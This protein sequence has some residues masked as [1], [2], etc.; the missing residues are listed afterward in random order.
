MSMDHL[1]RGHAPIPDAAW[2]E[3]DQEAKDRLT[4]LLAA[5][6]VVDWSGP[7]GWQW[8]STSLG[9]TEEISAPSLTSDASEH[10]ETTRVRRRK[11]LP[12]AEIRVGFTLD[13]DELVDVS[14]GALDADLGA[15]D[16]AAQRVAAL[17]NHAVFHGWP[18]AGM[19][20]ITTTQPSYRL[21]DDAN[22]FPATIARS[23][24]TLDRSGIGGPYALVI[25]PVGY[26]CIMET[27]EHGGYPLIEHL[28]TILGGPVI[29][30]PGVEGALVVTQRGGD[31]LF[32]SGQD[33]SVGYLS[34]DAETVD[35][36][37]E[38]SFTFR[39]VE[40]DAAVRL[41]D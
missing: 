30:A 18:A 1:I 34:H 20:G 21:G 17:E 8:S 2:Q 32:E 12:V 24:D 31:F 38:E 39:C 23:V 7:H 26:T 5:R 15:L 19:D 3:I 10:D 37:L 16:H 29:S 6:R 14:R 4:P 9:R 25:G 40:D 28:R 35:L 33:L 11:V 27:A 41:T 13:R 22:A 36:Y